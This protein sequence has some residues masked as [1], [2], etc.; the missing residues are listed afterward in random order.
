MKIN[1]ISGNIKYFGQSLFEVIL[2]LAVATIIIMAIVSLTSKT[3]STSTY[4]SNKAQAGRYLSEAMEYLRK[5]KQFGTWNTLKTNITAGGGVWCMTNL[6]L[7]K[8]YACNPATSGD[9][10]PGTI[11]QRTVTASATVSTVNVEI[12]VT[13]VD[14]QGSHAVNTISAISNW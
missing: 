2:A 9:F 11:F 5:E 13:W 10:I 6:S 4:S 1:S 12:T 14:E 8:N 7:T 3:V